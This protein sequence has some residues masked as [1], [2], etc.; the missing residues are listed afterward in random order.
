MK[1]AIVEKVIEFRRFYREYTFRTYTNYASRGCCKEKITSVEMAV[2]PK[3]RL[4]WTP[5]SGICVTFS[6]IPAEDIPMVALNLGF[7]INV[8]QE[9]VVLAKKLKKYNRKA[10]RNMK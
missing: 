3:C 9:Y 4:I 1:E 6:G 2:G 8:L 5:S 10:K 7:Y